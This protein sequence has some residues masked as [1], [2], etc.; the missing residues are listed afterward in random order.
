MKIKI[1][2]FIFI[3]VFSINFTYAENKCEIKD[4]QFNDIFD[5]IS[6][7]SHRKI[8]LENNVYIGTEFIFL[9]E[10]D[11]LKSKIL[12]YDNWINIIDNNLI[13]RLYKEL[14]LKEYYMNENE[15]NIIFNKI[16]QINFKTISEKELK[17]NFNKKN[18]LN[19]L[20]NYFLLENLVSLMNC[21]PN[22]VINNINFTNNLLKSNLIKEDYYTDYAWYADVLYNFTYNNYYIIQARIFEI[23]ANFLEGN[24]DRIKDDRNLTIF[25]ENT[26]SIIDLASDNER[27]ISLLQYIDYIFN[28]KSSD[29]Y[30]W[31]QYY[32]DKL[33]IIEAWENKN[34]WCVEY[35]W[36]WECKTKFS[37]KENIVVAV[38]DDWINLNNLDITNKIWTNQ[39]EIPW[40]KIDD[41]KNWYVDD[42][43]GWN[44]YYNDNNTLPMWEHWTA[45]AWIIWAE[46]NNWIWMAWIIPNA[47]IMSLWVFNETWETETENIIKAVNYAIDNNADIINLSLAWTQFIFTQEYNAVFK[48]AYEKNIPIIISAWNGDI[49]SW[50][51]IWVNTTVNKLSP[52]C[53]DYWNEK[54]IFWVWSLQEDWEK[55]KWSNYWDCVDFW[56]FWENIF[57]LS[58]WDE[59]SE[60]GENYN[61]FYWTSFSA[62]ILSWIIWLWINKVWNVKIDLIYDAL[63]KSWNWNIIDVNLFI[64]NLIILSNEES[65]KQ[66]EIRKQ[67]SMKKLQNLA[68][69]KNE[70]RI[71]KMENDSKKVPE[72]TE[73][74]QDFYVNSLLFIKNNYL[75]ILLSFIIIILWFVSFKQR[76]N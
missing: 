14:I 68:K 26:F 20:I 64:D 25:S 55:S 50:W 16:S 5:K 60:Y 28:L 36:T 73:I 56:T 41:D 9:R 52:V 39:K 3:T 62:P 31:E 49:L 47:K 43:N 15:V 72:E 21:N 13:I 4:F 69:K 66:E 18:E 74:N 12:K 57:S 1:L 44:F 10:F 48:K 59:D 19:F 32:L 75:V 61:K 76:K 29:E 63:K 6:E 27:N 67:E 40:N 54:I 7:L 58:L 33:N 45:V 42:F 46:S 2:L 22:N 65:K 35:F 71:Q 24:L 37:W 53:N 11:T 38:I 23:Y 34:F 70:E 51:K 8:F 17:N 30:S